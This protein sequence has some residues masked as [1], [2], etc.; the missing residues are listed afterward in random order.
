MG[1]ATEE[2]TTIAESD[3]KFAPREKWEETPKREHQGVNTQARAQRQSL[4]DNAKEVSEKASARGRVNA[5]ATQPGP[6]TEKIYTT[7]LQVNEEKPKI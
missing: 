1:E 7:T 3:H 5:A 2:A 6:R 4:G